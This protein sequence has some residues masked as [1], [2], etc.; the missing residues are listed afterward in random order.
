MSTM[1]AFVKLELLRVKTNTNH[2]A[3]KTK[4]YIAA[5]RTAF[6]QLR[7][8]EPQPLESTGRVT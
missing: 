5:L 3:L 8:L 4:L 2:F 1:F 6:D 7:V